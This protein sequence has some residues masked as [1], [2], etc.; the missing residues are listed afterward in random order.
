MRKRLPVLKS[1]PLETGLITVSESWPTIMTS[2]D[3]SPDHVFTPKRFLKVNESRHL[4]LDRI[5]LGHIYLPLMHIDKRPI[6]CFIQQLLGCCGQRP[7]YQISCI[8]ATSVPQL[9][10]FYLWWQANIYAT[11][12]TA[13]S[14]DDLRHWYSDNQVSVLTQC[15]FSQKKQA[16]SYMKYGAFCGPITII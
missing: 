16:A 11:V 6:S 13:G 7:L 1:S 5:T 2:W 8:H 4:E 14:Y 3:Q 12:N 15:D 9:P 10:C